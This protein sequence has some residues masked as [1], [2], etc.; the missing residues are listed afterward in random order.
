MI[1]DALEL[2]DEDEIEEEADE[3]VEKILFEITD[4]KLGQA[5]SVAKLKTPEVPVEEE[6]EDEMEKRLAALKSV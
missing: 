2:G 3:E 4:G 6:Q 1:E 5:G